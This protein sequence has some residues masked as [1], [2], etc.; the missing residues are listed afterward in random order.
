MTTFK[1]PA[2]VLYQSPSG[3]F[4]E[5]IAVRP[6]SGLLLTSILSPTLHTL[7]PAAEN[8]TLDEVYTFPKAN[9]L[10]GIA[11]Y[12]P[13]VYAVV[14]S[15]LNPAAGTAEPGS[16]AIW[17][18]DL[19]SAVVAPQLVARIPQSKL[20]NGLST[21][22]GAPDLV[23]GAD[24]HLGA[25][26]EINMRTGAVRVLIQDAALAPGPDAPWP[27]L[28][29]N[30]LRT[31]DGALYYTN[32]A[33]G[34]FGRI[35]LGGGAVEV[36]GDLSSFGVTGG[37]G[38][39]DF[40]FDGEGRA[41]VTLHPGALQLFS[42][43]EDGTWVQETAVGVPAGSDILK[44]PTAAAFGRD[45]AGNATKTLYVITTAGQ[46]VIVDTNVKP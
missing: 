20:I 33:L 5:N 28:G 2:K 18:V 30:G 12:Q 11:E 46:I 32:S 6:S 37:P 4:L 10:T 35:P 7:D 13:D 40:V 23:L 34:T 9:G 15:Q 21:V 25:A 26:Y 24:S 3:L 16:T 22:P 17:T 43:R 27:G 41:W 45:G 19:T 36:L 39:D 38:Y 44:G 14:A 1:F 42:P 8:A 29:I 31:R